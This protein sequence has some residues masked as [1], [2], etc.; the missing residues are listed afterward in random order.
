MKND[1]LLPQ[2]VYEH[3]TLTQGP[4]TLP[5]WGAFVVQ[6]SGAANVTAGQWV[7]R[8]EHVRSGQV[9]HFQSVDDLLT[10]IARVLTD[11]H[12]QAKSEG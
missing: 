9:T 6:F 11:R 12:L 8:V 5:L 7:G 3:Q 4:S 2:P 10:F 1:S